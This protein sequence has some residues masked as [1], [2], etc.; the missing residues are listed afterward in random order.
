MTIDDCYQLGYIIK[1][2]GLNGEVQVYLD[3]DDPAKYQDLESVFVQQGQQLVPFFIEY[4]KTNPSKSLLAFEEINS[5]E[6]AAPLKGKALFLP[7]NVLEEAEE[8]EF[9]IHEIQDFKL[10]DQ[11][12]NVVGT[13]INAIEAGPQLILAVK[14]EKHNELLVPYSPELLIDIDRKNKQLQI[15]IADGLLEVYTKDQD[16]D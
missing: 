4:I 15:H 12:G 11:E 16:E 2:H 8:D 1:P 6:E 7:L 5:I 13:I 3:V 9:Y 10:S 14:A